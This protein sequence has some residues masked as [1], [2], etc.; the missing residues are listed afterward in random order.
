M[1]EF[2]EFLVISLGFLDRFVWVDF[3][4]Y[5]ID[6]FCL[7][8]FGLV[9]FNLVK[10]NLK[11]IFKG[12]IDCVG[13]FLVFGYEDCVGDEGYCWIKVFGCFD[14]C[15]FYL[16][17]KVFK[18]VIVMDVLCFVL[19]EKDDLMIMIVVV[20]ED[21]IKMLKGKDKVLFDFGKLLFFC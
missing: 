21:G 15:W 7:S 8:Y 2:Y 19:S 9:F 10:V 14:L 20:D 17:I 6:Y 5:G 12:K 1:I 4:I 11:K 3:E 16:L 18:W 13:I